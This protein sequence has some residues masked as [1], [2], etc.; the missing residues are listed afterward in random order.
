VDGCAARAENTEF[1]CSPISRLAET[2]NAT[3]KTSFR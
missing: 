3:V 1:G 2:P